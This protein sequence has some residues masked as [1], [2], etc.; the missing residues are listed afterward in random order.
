[1]VMKVHSPNMP[2][3]G[4]AYAY[5]LEKVEVHPKIKECI[6]QLANDVA[7]VTKRL[8]ETNEVLINLSNALMAVAAMDIGVIEGAYKKKNG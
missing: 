6:C 7:E 1:M 4:V 5:E 2:K 3:L 8:N